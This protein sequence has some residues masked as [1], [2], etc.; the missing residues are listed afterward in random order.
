MRRLISFCLLAILL[1]VGNAFALQIKATR[2]SGY[3]SG[4]GGEFTIQVIDDDAN[5]LGNLPDPYVMNTTAFDPNIV[6][7]LLY[8]A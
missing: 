1:S 3:F 6:P 7:D 2:A 4:I 8:R 5:I